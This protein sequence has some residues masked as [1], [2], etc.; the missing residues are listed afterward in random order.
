MEGE[1]LRHTLGRLH[2]HWMILFLI[3]LV[4]ALG[5]IFGRHLN[6]SREATRALSEVYGNHP[7]YEFIQETPHPTR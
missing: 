1:H 3:G 2:H 5:S 4:I 7:H 6:D